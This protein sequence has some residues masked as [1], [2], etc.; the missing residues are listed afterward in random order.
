[1]LPLFESV[2]SFTELRAF[3]A[4]AIKHKRLMLLC[5][6]LGVAV[7]MT[8]TVY[9]Q[10]VYYSKSLI[11]VISTEPLPVDA[12]V[13]FR[14]SA[15]SSIV[16]QLNS[17]HI[18][19]RTA[20][21]LGHKIRHSTIKSDLVKMQVVKPN[22]EGD[23]EI[24]IWPYSS[25][26]N[27]TWAKNLIDQ[28]LTY[29]EEKRLEL[30]EKRIATFTAELAQ[31]RDRIE[32][33]EQERLDFLQNQSVDE[34]KRQIAELS[35]VPSELAAV[36]QKISFVEPIIKRL[37][38]DNLS[39]IEQLS[40]IASTRKKIEQLS[41]GAI[42][43]ISK[44]PSSHQ[45]QSVIITPDILAEETWMR[46]DREQ[47][48]LNQEIEDALKIYLPGHQKVLKLTEQAAK[49]NQ[50]IMLELDMVKKR[51][52]LECSE[53]FTQKNTLI[54][55]HD[56]LQALLR[57]DSALERDFS[58]LQANRLAWESMYSKIAKSLEVLD[59]GADKERVNLQY[60]GFLDF[61]EQPVSP[62]RLKVLLYSL[63]FR[64]S[65]NIWTI[66]YHLTS[67]FT[68]SSACEQSG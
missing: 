52:D 59:Y 40:L 18:A 14:D 54:K 3:L 23:L 41:I 47:R 32:R 22:S 38:T 29:R 60:M 35:P 39:P 11:R 68:A 31:I 1:M 58:R 20:L 64:L 50:N 61:R 33:F 30:R 42:V 16:G 21:A 43:P 4:I 7:G 44:E 55:K 10:P 36:N 48:R 2:L 56:L 66:P 45:A 12:Q 37:Q 67:R 5:I 28:F 17:P 63:Q 27:Q 57:S 46:M 34:R 9:K 65:W 15:M 24:E 19:E 25:A 62:Y 26:I 6:C 8:Y 13:V 53:L 51:F 49:L